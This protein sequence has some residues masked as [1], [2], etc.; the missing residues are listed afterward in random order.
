MNDRNEV[1]D[2]KVRA[3]F[4][5]SR[6]KEFTVGVPHEV[7]DRI[8]VVR[9][10]FRI[11]D[12]LPQDNGESVRWIWQLGGWLM[13]DRV[14]GRVTQLNL[15]DFDL[16]SSNVAW[17]RDYA[18]YCGF[19]ENGKNWFA[20]VVQMGRRKTVLKKTLGSAPDESGRAACSTPEWQ[21]QP[22]RVT[23]GPVNNQKFTYSIRGTVANFLDD[24]EEEQAE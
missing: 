12:A 17:F 22:V 15:P 8:F 2:L 6:V 1:A 21:R 9:R 20:I 19:S 7:T 24:P 4:V 18:A 23:F 13:V 10:A 5:D 14:S 16:S 3:L 11:N